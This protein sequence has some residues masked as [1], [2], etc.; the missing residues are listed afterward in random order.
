M[1]DE[2]IDRIRVL[3]AQFNQDREMEGFSDGQKSKRSGA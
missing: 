1:T 2:E 3:A